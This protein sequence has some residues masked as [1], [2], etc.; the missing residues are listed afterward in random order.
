MVIL[1][2]MM[3]RFGEIKMERHEKQNWAVLVEARLLILWHIFDLLSTLFLKLLKCCHLHD[4]FQIIQIYYHIMT[5]N[6]LP[7]EQTN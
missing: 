4:H 5:L 7:I 2:G 3:D 6:I 1:Y